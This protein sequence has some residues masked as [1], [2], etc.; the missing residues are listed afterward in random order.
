MVLGRCYLLAVLQRVTT[1]EVALRT[2]VSESAVRKWRAGSHTPAPRV[3]VA[4]E[5]HLRIPSSA[6]DEQPVKLVRS[7]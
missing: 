2:R 7:I 3:R 1:S 4:L 6:W 5:V